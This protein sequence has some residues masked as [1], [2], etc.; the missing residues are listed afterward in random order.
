[1]SGNAVETG[2]LHFYWKNVTYCFFHSRS[3]LFSRFQV[4]SITAGFQL[5]IIV[6][7]I[8]NNGFK[9][10]T[11]AFL[12]A[13]ILRMVN[14]NL[15]AE[16]FKKSVIF[17]RE[18]IRCHSVIIKQFLIQ[19]VTVQSGFHL[20]CKSSFT[21]QERRN[22]FLGKGAHFQVNHR[23]FSLQGIMPVPFLYSGFVGFHICQLQLL[24]CGFS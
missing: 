14:M 5:F 22:D 11:Q 9:M 20:L 23:L 12:T 3:F 10:M 7:Q 16:Q 8:F 4:H 21:F 24:F 1:M 17:H 15:Y 18:I 6:F 19:K 13:G 2:H